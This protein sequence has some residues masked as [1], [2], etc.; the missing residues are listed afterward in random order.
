MGK[1]RGCLN[2]AQSK[3]PKDF[4]KVKN[5]VGKKKKDACNSTDRVADNYSAKKIVM[6]SQL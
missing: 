2:K 1:N 5:K 3:K 4:D 6:P